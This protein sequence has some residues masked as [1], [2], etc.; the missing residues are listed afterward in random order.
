MATIIIEATEETATEEILSDIIEE[1]L[2]QS[3][4]ELDRKN[5]VYANAR[6]LLDHLQK[7]LNGTKDFYHSEAKV[8]VLRRI[9][10]L[11][12][13]NFEYLDDLARALADQANQRKFPVTASFTGDGYS[14]Q[15]SQEQRSLLEYFIKIRYGCDIDDYDINRDTKE[16][17][18]K[19]SNFVSITVQRR[20]NHHYLDKLRS[21]FKAL[22][23]AAGLATGMFFYSSSTPQTYSELTVDKNQFT[24]VDDKKTDDPDDYIVFLERG[25]RKQHVHFCPNQSQIVLAVGDT[26]K[27]IE[28]SD[29]S[30]LKMLVYSSQDYDVKVTPQKSLKLI[31]PGTKQTA[32]QQYR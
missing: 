24:V 14:S 31:I 25:K 3:V 9:E 12:G 1:L 20:I 29:W 11:N 4:L 2:K 26:H 23:V 6:F 7:S 28:I 21:R 13:G 22:A 16:N 32:E 18:W 19:S 10:T 8:A 27:I 5:S 15:K 17:P 30:E